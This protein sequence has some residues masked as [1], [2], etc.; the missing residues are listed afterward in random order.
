MLIGS[1]IFEKADKVICVSEYEKRNIMKDFGVPEV[2]LE[3]I[4]NGLNLAEFINIISSKKH[5]GMRTLLYVGRLEKYKGVQ[6]IINALP[7]L[8]DFRLE[9]IGKGAF[10]SNLRKLA[11]KLSVAERMK[12]YKNITREELLQHYASA[13]V[14][15]MLSSHEAYGITVAEA[16]MS[17]TPCIVALGSALDEFADGERCIGIGTPVTNE[18]LISAIQ[19]LKESNIKG[20]MSIKN[21]PVH[22]WKDVTDKLIELYRGIQ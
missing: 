8:K 17:G 18:K 19:Q 2:K 22:D 1:K 10:E 20:N 6:H 7:R 3:K 14:F 15:L 12:W 4:P 5:D 13:D 11:E 9:I 16:L 21:L